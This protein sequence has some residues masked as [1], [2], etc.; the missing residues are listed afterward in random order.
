MAPY[1]MA[2]SEVTISETFDGTIDPDEISMQ[3][4]SQHLIAKAQ[5]FQELG[6]D[7]EQDEAGRLVELFPGTEVVESKSAAKAKPAARRL[8]A[9]PEPE[10]EDEPEDEPAPRRTAP[11]APRAAAPARPAARRAAPKPKGDDDDPYGDWQDLTDDPDS[12]DYFAE[13]NTPKAPDFRHKTRKQA[14]SNYRV[15]L[16]LD[17]APSWFENPFE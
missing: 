1:E 13:K 10:P 7:F 9:A 8:R 17:N 15:S 11:R 16:W 2:T 14:N 5:V 6:L 4:A 3:V 12:W